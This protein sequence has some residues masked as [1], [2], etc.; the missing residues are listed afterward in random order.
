MTSTAD[1]P[2]RRKLGSRVLDGVERLGNS[3]PDPIFL[4]IILIAILFVVSAIAERLSELDGEHAE[5]YR[6]NAEATKAQLQALDAEIRT[7]LAPVSAKP[8]ITFHDGY[9][10]FVARYGLHQAGR[11][12]VHPEQQAGAAS[13]RA[14]KEQVVEQKIVCAFAEPQF[15]PEALEA[16]AGTA[17]INV[18]ILDA[19][20]ADLEP[21]PGLYGLLLRKNAAAIAACLTS[22][23]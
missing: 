12:S 18:G 16:L 15:D 6:R 8:F 23:S 14:L 11:L 9:G 2:R 13:L 17:E 22:T 4:F 20:G 5:A 19:I 21:G 10:Y 7:I 3:L 1:D